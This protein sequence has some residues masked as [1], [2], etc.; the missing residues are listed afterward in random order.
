MSGAASSSFSTARLWC[1]ERDQRDQGC[2]R[3]GAPDEIRARRGRPRAVCPVELERCR[4]RIDV[5]AV[6]VDDGE[7]AARRVVRARQVPGHDHRPRAVDHEALL[8]GDRD[9]RRCPLHRDPVRCEVLER[10]RVVR[11]AVVLLVEEHADDDTSGGVVDQGFLGVAVAELVHRHVDRVLRRPEEPVD[12]R[13]ALIGLDDQGA[14]PAARPAHPGGK[15][16]GGEQG[17]DRHDETNAPPG[18]AWSAAIVPPRHVHRV[19]SHRRLVRSEFDRATGRRAC[20]TS[21]GCDGFGRART[22]AAAARLRGR[23]RPGVSESDDLRL[24]SW[25]GP[26]AWSIG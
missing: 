15:R 21:R 20:L 6:G 5:A 11:A 14:E 24:A 4:D 26:V 18:R 9:L 17:R 22:A 8:M 25:F 19:E 1:A 7:V 12:R 23:R 10:R 2:L 13:V 16:R 3:A